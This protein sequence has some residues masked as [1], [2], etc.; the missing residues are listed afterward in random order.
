MDMGIYPHIHFGK[1][2]KI[3]GYKSLE[4]NREYN[5]LNRRVPATLVN[6]LL[7]CFGISY[8]SFLDNLHS[9]FSFFDNFLFLSR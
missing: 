3:Q 7:L 5:N 1:S 8:F 9:Y 2:K 4:Q 6:F